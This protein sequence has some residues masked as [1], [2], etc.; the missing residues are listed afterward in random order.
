MTMCNSQVNTASYLAS[1][2]ASVFNAEKKIISICEITR[3]NLL[4]DFFCLSHTFYSLPHFSSGQVA[5][6]SG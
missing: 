6:L 2:A 5:H 3:A 4:V 1:K